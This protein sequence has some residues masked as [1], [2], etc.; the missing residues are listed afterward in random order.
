MSRIISKSIIFAGIT[1][2]LLSCKASEPTGSAEGNLYPYLEDQEVG[3]LDNNLTKKIDPKFKF[4]QTPI[5]P[6]TFSEGLAAV[7]FLGSIGYID[8]NGSIAIDPQFDHAEAFNEGTALVRV[9]MQYGFINRKGD[10]IIE[11]TFHKAGRFSEGLAP[12]Q[13]HR[14]SSWGYLNKNGKNRRTVCFCRNV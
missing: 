1:L 6:Y 2:L 7:N 14:T 10:F 11:P 4:V 12:V 8:R 13:D 3:F 5:W 9:N